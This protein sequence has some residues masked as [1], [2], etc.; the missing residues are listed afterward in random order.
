MT[1]NYSFS[2]CP[3]CESTRFEIV[4]D[5]PTNSNWKYF[6]VRCSS[7]KSVISVKEYF[8]IGSLLH[9]IMNKLGIPS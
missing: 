8:N 2:K 7:C 4:E 9:K 1:N 5:T 6:Y 3:K